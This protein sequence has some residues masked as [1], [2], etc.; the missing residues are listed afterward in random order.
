MNSNSGKDKD[1]NRLL[2]KTLKK[3]GLNY[4]DDQG[5]HLS[6]DKS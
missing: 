1:K 2:F 4:K 3:L 5:K 6:F